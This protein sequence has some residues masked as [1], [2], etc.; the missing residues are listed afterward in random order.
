M[1]DVTRWTEHHRYDAVVVEN[2]VEAK[3][4]CDEHALPPLRPGGKPRGCS[5]GVTFEKWKRQMLDLGYEAEEVYFNSQHAGVP[6]S[7]DRLYVVFWRTGIKPPRLDFQPTAWC[8]S[9]ERVVHGVQTWKKPSRNSGR[10]RDRRLLRWGRYGKQYLYTC[11]SCTAVVAP[12]VLG[13]WAII[14]HTLR[15]ASIGSR[16]KP[17]AAATRNR[18]RTGLVRIGRHRPVQLQ[19]GGNLFER[20]GYARLWSID[21]PLRTVTTTRTMAMLTP[22]GSR[23]GKAKPMSDPS[24]TL[25]GSHRLAAVIPNKTGN[26]GGSLEQPAGAVT[27]SPAG[28]MLVALRRHGKG[29]A[30][31]VPAPSVTAGGHHH[32]LVALRD[33]MDDR[34]IAVLV[35]N[36]NPGHVRVLE[37][38]VRITV[39]RP[40]QAEPPRA[41]QP[42]RRAPAR[43]P[44]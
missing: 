28:H 30:D 9:C 19:V 33:G 25:T 6:Q 20:P 17:I 42:D 37:R 18:I 12:A 39:D 13:S 5:C 10:A 29:Q 4:W 36:G 3:L 21:D 15:I 26:L 22:A 24:Q 34:Q 23:E 35:Y 43:S 1:W 16:K 32:G 38:R 14:D 40:G 8:S 7:R 41:L 27:T 31:G 44:V 2:V 11:P